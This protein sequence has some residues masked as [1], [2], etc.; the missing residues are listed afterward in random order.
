MSTQTPGYNLPARVLH[1]LVL[2]LLTVQFIGA[3]ILPEGEDGAVQSQPAAG[4]L[5][6]WHMSLGVLIALVVLVRLAWRA[7]WTAPPL[8]TALPAWQE[9]A[10]RLTHLALYGLLLTIPLAGW[11]W[12]SAKGWTVT[13]FHTASLPGLVSSGTLPD[14]LGN[15]HAL[16]ANLMLAAA[17]L[18]VA[19][20]LWHHFVL[21][22]G[23]LSR[24]WRSPQG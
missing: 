2:G 20:A 11:A 19:A 24:M 9:K 7:T 23:L 4:S 1:W 21:R 14:L 12:A 16:L 13:L 3:Q 22:D 6:D 15:L 10:S 8:P 17:G 18:H 5:V